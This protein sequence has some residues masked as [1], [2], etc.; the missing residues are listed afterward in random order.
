MDYKE[1]LHYQLSE[2]TFSKITKLINLKNFFYLIL[3]KILLYYFNLKF[4]FLKI[5]LPTPF[6]VGR[7]GEGKRIK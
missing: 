6:R 4:D 1:A 5:K 3:I 2:T 7:R